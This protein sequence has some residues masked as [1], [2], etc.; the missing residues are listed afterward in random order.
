M[1]TKSFTTDFRINKK[2][3]EKIVSSIADSRR[4]DHNIKQRVETIR[5]KERINKV[6]SNL[7]IEK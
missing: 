6:M 1:A 4:V 3:S 7:F 2:T 5:D